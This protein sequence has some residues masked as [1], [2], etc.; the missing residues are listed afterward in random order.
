MNTN[1]AIITAG[2]VIEFESEGIAVSAL[3]LLTSEDAVIL[4]LLDGSMPIVAK[5][6]ELGEFR[7]FTPDAEDL[8]PVAA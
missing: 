4:D 1:T 7:L 2:D 8:I 5:F 3:V 6:V